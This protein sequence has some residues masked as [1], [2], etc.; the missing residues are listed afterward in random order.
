VVLAG[1]E[2]RHAAVAEATGSPGRPL[3]EDEIVAKFV[4]NAAP[5]AGAAAA[6][7]LAQH[8]LAVAYADDVRGLVAAATA[9]DLGAV[10]AG[11]A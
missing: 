2:E 11:E 9:E 4:A 7:E 6:A 5:P 10:R 1:G 3:G 8:L